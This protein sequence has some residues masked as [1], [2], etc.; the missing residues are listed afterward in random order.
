M[1]LF[2]RKALEEHPGNEG[3]LKLQKNIATTKPMPSFHFP[4]LVMCH[5]AAGSY[6]EKPPSTMAAH[7]ERRGF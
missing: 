1:L 4:V 3:C 5:S 2:S 6:C 7:R